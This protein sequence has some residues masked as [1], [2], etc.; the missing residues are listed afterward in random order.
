[1]AADGPWTESGPASRWGGVGRR[2]DPIAI[3]TG[4]SVT[5]ISRGPRGWL[6]VPDRGRPSPHAAQSP[7]QGA[8]AEEVSRGTTPPTL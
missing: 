6:T 2:D 4:G 1:M 8:A 5:V 3:R 7:N